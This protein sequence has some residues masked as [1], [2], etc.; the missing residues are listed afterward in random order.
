MG[1]AVLGGLLGLGLGAF[2]ARML[3]T[4]RAPA[5]IGRSFRTVRE[6]G[7]YHLLFGLALLIFVMGARL[8]GSRTAPGTALFALVL[9]GVAVSRFRPRGRRRDDE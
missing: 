9:V 8:A 7:C 6:A 1:T 2:G 5:I 3:I 4:D